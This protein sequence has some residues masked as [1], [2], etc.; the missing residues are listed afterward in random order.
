MS[1]HWHE[2]GSEIVPCPV[3][4]C[5]W[6]EPDEPAPDNSVA[7]APG[8][9]CADPEPHVPHEE[10]PGSA[11]E[12]PSADADAEARR[13]YAEVGFFGG[14]GTEYDPDSGTYR[15][16]EFPED[17]QGAGPM[18]AAVPMGEEWLLLAV[19]DATTYAVESPYGASP[20]MTIEQA[21]AAHRAYGGWSV[22]LDRADAEQ[23]ADARDGMYVRYEGLAAYNELTP[24]REAMFGEPEA[25]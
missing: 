7:V 1:G 10:C 21:E 20:D 25:H 12:F 2:V 15:E 22:F 8:G 23:V 16:A 24:A 13:Y 6:N 3:S 17:F 18:Y 19:R 4:D 5:F 11:P 14:P 9:P